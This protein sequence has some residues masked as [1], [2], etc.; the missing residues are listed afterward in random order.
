MLGRADLI[1]A[2]RANGSPHQRL[3]RALKV[4]KEEVA[5]LV[6]ALE[7]YMAKDPDEE[8]ANW[9]RI[10]SFWISALSDLPGVK[11]RR[12]FPNNLGRPI[13]QLLFEVDES[14]GTSADA[15][16]ED[17]WAGTPRVMVLRRGGPRTFYLSPE[18]ATDKEA[19]VIAERIRVSTRKLMN[20]QA[21]G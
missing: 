8:R 17:M 3:A 12:Q 7:V 18:T 11:A 15:I 20:K 16:A 21:I 13:P 9:E 14:T 4:G 19:E 1:A 2:A 10:V 5:G 6:R